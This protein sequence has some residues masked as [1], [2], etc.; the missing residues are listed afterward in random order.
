MAKHRQLVLVDFQ[1]RNC[2]LQDAPSLEA[3]GL[4]LRSQILPQLSVGHT[5]RAYIQYLN[6]SAAAD[7]YPKVGSK[8]QHL[9]FLLPLQV[10]CGKPTGLSRTRQ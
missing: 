3:A 7:Q 9:A 4:I 5:T 8:Q 10:L 6:I 1:N 2:L